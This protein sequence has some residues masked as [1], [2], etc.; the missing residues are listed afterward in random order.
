ME[1]NATSKF[2]AVGSL[3]SS[4]VREAATLVKSGRVYSLAV[5]TSAQSPAYPGRT[6]QILT[7]RILIDGSG[8]YGKNR[9]QGF[10]DFVCLWCGVGTHLDGFAHVAVDGL[11]YGDVASAEVIQPRGAV[12]YGIET[13]PPIATRGVLL[14]VPRALGIPALEAGYEIRRGD[15]ERA[16]ALQQT[17]PRPGDVVLVHTGW[18]KD[19]KNRGAFV[20]TEPGIGSEAAAYLVEEKGIVAFGSDNWALEV[21]PAADAEAFLPVH[22]YLLREKGVHIIENVWTRDLATDRVYEFLFILAAPKLVGALQSP[23]HPIAIA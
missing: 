22:G 14:D 15:L 13:V 17:E 5:E 11:H 18:L 2:G 10:D 20:D 19:P 16:F 6:Y 1:R 4:Q 3:T 21:I 8:T 9:L 12:R 7:D 23:V